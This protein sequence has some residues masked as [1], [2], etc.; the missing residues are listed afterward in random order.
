MIKRPP[1]PGDGSG[2]VRKLYA[3]TESC[4]RKNCE[5]SCSAMEM[6]TVQLQKLKVGVVRALSSINRAVPQFKY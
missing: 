4:A 3:S 1:K 2:F 5:T 6:L